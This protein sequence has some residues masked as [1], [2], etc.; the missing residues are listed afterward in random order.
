[1]KTFAPAVLSVA[2]ATLAHAQS[3]TNLGVGA[4]DHDMSRAIGVSADGR[5]VT[6]ISA[7]SSSSQRAYRWSVDGGFQF[8][9]SPNSTTPYGISGDGSTVVGQG[10]S[11]PTSGGAFRWSSGAI[12]II[13]GSGWFATAA[14][15]DA[16][17]IVGA[18]GSGNREAVRWVNGSQQTLGSLAPGAR[19]TALAVSSDGLTIVGE[20]ATSFSGGQV[21][22]RW[23]PFGGMES[24]GTLN[25]YG[26]SRAAS[27]SADGGI[28]VGTSSTAVG[29][30]DLAFRWTAS[31]G[32]QS[33]GAIAGGNSSSATAI[34]SDGTLI[35]GFGGLSDGSQGAFI[36]HDT[37][38]MV[39]LKDYLIG[40][41]VN[42][43]GWEQLLK[44]TGVS[45]DGRFVVGNGIF[46]GAERAFIAD[47]GVIPTPAAL[48]VLVAGG[49]VT[50][51]RRG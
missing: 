32:M 2:V 30:S 28:I 1:M 51:R 14:N 33:L 7:G 46:N 50:R 16:S 18:T 39:Y 41:G 38:G 20:A 37:L 35:V 17:V 22:F 21:A 49:L 27:V 15:F 31:A 45:A 43:T 36:H 42:M 47:I 8:F 26:G 44:A 6:G 19:S 12:Q 25:G 3:I 23:R 40:R 9:G 10:D 4:V 5:F 48:T 29:Q 24:L 34:S 11:Y 13:G